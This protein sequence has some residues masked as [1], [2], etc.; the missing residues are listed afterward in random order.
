MRWL[1][2][3]SAGQN[4]KNAM[5]R[6]CYSV[7]GALVNLKHTV[8]IWGL[9]HENEKETPEFRTIRCHIHNRKLRIRMVAG[10]YKNK[11]TIK[12]PLDN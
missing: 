11:K 4:E 6:E 2:I 7:G 10:F 5:L 9:R 8:D 1:I 3:Q 12:I